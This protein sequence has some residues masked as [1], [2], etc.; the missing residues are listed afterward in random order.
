MQAAD[1]STKCH[2]HMDISKDKEALQ[3]STGQL[4]SILRL[5]QAGFKDVVHLEGG[6]SQWR[7]DKYPVDGK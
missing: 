6:L 4:R 3:V 2:A 5:Q 7:H 1:F